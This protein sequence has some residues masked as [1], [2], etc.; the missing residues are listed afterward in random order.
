MKTSD[1]D[2]HLPP[3]LIAQQP[4]AD[5]AASRMMVVDRATGEIRHDQFRNIGRCLRAGDLLVLNDTKV[6]PARIWS[7]EPEV[8]LL[9]VEKLGPDRWSALVKPG[10]RAKVGATLQFEDGVSGVIEGETDFGG[11]TLRFSGDVEAY[12]AAHGVAPLPPYIKRAMA[13]RRDV[14]E[15]RIANVTRRCLRASRA[16]W[17]RRRRDCISPRRCWSNFSPQASVTRSSRCTSASA[18]FGP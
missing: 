3:E 13:D 6:I 16:R 18:R 12:M 8:E 1:F 11:R 17:P 5:R 14:R 10:K 7:R 9:L 4:L 2:Y 15:T